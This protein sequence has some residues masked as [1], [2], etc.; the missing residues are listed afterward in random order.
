MSIVLH[1]ERLVIDEALLGGERASNVRATIECELARRL[2]RPG[3]ID[4]L[5][6]IDA[7]AALPTVALPQ[8]APM[9]GPLG[10][11]IAMAVQQGLGLHP[12][13]GAKDHG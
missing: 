6:G 10:A 9:Q 7:V 2:A 8:P 13:N 11:R 1:I 4:A 5:R 3:G 12:S